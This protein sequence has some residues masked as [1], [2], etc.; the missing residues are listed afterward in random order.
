MAEAVFIKYSDLPNNCAANLIIFRQK[1]TP[2]QP[3]TRLFGRLEYT[4]GNSEIQ[5][6]NFYSSRGRPFLT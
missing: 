3:S 2:A 6:Q 5:I 1:N 4:F